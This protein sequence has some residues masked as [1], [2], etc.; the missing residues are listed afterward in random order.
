MRKE[1]ENDT[2]ARPIACGCCDGMAEM[3]S[4]RFRSFGE[5]SMFS[6][7][8]KENWEGLCGQRAGEAANG[9]DQECSG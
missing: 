6:A 7:W 3:M 1:E 8:M 9:E 5:Y 4:R 2:K